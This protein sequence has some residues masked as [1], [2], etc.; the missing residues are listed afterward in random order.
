MTSLISTV[1]IRYDDFGTPAKL[2]KTA[3]AA[4]QTEKAFDQ[5][6]GKAALGS[7]KL[8]LFGNSAVA[9]G[10]K[11]KIGLN[12]YQQSNV[13]LLQELNQKLVL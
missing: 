11:S 12:L 6:A 9:T 3:V 10:V 7:K 8:G 1:G 2:K 13:F 5:L 4:K